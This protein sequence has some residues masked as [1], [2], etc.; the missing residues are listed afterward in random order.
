MSSSSRLYVSVALVPLLALSACGGGGGPSVASTPT[1]PPV[2]AAAPPPPP[3][4]PPVNYRT[5]EYNRSNAAV[6]AQAIA[7]Y[8]SGA[9]GAGITVGVIDSGVD[10]GSAEFAGRISPA[11]ADLAGSRGLQDESGHGSA[12]SD[13]LLGAKNDT[14]ISG[15][16]FDAT[17]LV[18]RTDTPGSCATATAGSTD[19][20]CTHSD[21]AIARGLDLAVKTG[22]RVVN[23]SLGGAPANGNLRAAIN[24]ATAAGVIIVI[25][26]GNDGV[27]T[28]AVAGN[29]D[30]LAQ[31]AIDPIA[32]GL[33]LIAGAT[34]ATQTI[35][36]FSNRA[37]NSAAFYLT[38]L[39]VGVV[40][41][42]NKNVLFRWDGTS[43]S[44]PAVSGA[45]ALLAQAF[46]TLTSA[47]IIDLL[48]RTATDL[49]A[50]GIDSTYGHGELN[51]AK[52]FAPQGA[53]S[54]ANAAIPVSLTSNGT[55][56]A[57]MGD[58][59]QGSLGATIHDGYG[60][61]YAVNL[62]ATLRGAARASRLGGG[63]DLNGHSAAMASGPTTI[64]L[65][66]ADQFG[67]ATDVQPLRLSG[68]D[69]DHARA[70]AASIITRIDGHTQVALGFAQGSNGLTNA[71]TQRGAPA[72]LVS[73][74]ASG[75]RGF[76]LAA[77]GAFA[78]RHKVGGIGFTLS[79]ESGDVRLWE[80][81][82]SGP[83]S[84]RYRRYGYGDLGIGM[85]AAKGPLRVATRLS[86]MTERDTVLGARFSSA[87]GGGGATSWYADTN[88]TLALGE[89]TR[90]DGSLRRG[91]TQ[92]ATGPVRSGSTLMTQ[93]MSFD[94]QR[95]AVLKSGD[96]FAIRWSEPLRVTSGGLA[97][98]GL[99]TEIVQFALAPV[100]HERDLEG[101]YAMPIGLGQFTGNVY[102]RQQP[103]NYAA[104]PDDVGAAIRYSFGF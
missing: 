13:V 34:D 8:Q 12:V 30:P 98:T 9:T 4:P 23:I 66:I 48:L 55:L 89:S 90:F 73:D 60:R 83:T 67:P 52:A 35:A 42:N 2:P 84:D 44:A 49:G 65:S 57:A 102:W 33:V 25:S 14:G 59:G 18:L 85:D 69:A 53:L 103:G 81:G 37:G 38:A 63:L 100:G 82:E 19:N 40:A 68:R 97:L 24:A 56:S 15:I 101:V 72:F 79:A 92:V 75:S 88:A 104:A 78:I 58:A 39:G 27:K 28:P 61:G 91:W 99:G 45:I 74:D 10:T 6:Q 31:I 50:P 80:V 77:K 11:S 21:T 36:D 1:P 3:P 47:Q 71:L 16:A 43:F 26:A 93:A 87:L 62:G 95:A 94:V 5:A 86:H 51:L 41:V 54:L 70:L 29:P 22:A 64:A 7:A 17:L 76:D 46:P 32:H 96:S 20:G